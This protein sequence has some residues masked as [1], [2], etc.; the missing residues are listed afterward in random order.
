MDL[1][2][3]N[4]PPKHVCFEYL[5]AETC[6]QRARLPLRV[7]IFPHDC[8]DS[9]IATVKNFFGLYDGHGVSFE[10]KAGNTL[11]A[12]YEN[13]ENNMAIHVRV[14]DEVVPTSEANS[15]H[16][17]RLAPAFELA[18]NADPVSRPSSRAA[19][20]RSVSPPT[21]PGNRSISV[22][23]V[24]SRARKSRGDD[25][26]SD[27]DVGAASV[28]SSRRGKIDIVASAE[29]SVE[30]IVEGSRRKRSRFD[31]SVGLRRL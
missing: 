25:G 21:A 9:I 15:P 4:L 30:N 3:S 16:R 2:S 8:T 22:G 29:I 28:T 6:Q 20:Q 1:P 24:R 10:D 17:P 18:T 19:K 12:R 14:A 13:F 23:T 7:N 5:L 11:I 27:S 31:S 26:D